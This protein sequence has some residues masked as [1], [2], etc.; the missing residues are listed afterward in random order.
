VVGAT[1]GVYRDSRLNH[2]DWVKNAV[3]GTLYNY[4]QSFV[5]RKTPMWNNRQAACCYNAGGTL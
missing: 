4:V 3:N 5:A 2:C 1:S